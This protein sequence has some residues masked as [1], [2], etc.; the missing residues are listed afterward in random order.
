MRFLRGIMRDME[1]VEEV[2]WKKRLKEI[3]ERMEKEERAR[4]QRIEKARK[5]QKSW[6]LNRECR[7]IIKELNNNWISLED[8]MEERRGGRSRLRRQG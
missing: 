3:L 7:K 2:D 1:L 5:L 4:I 6:E 8:R